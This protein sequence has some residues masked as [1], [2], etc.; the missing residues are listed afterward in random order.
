MF[1]RFGL[2]L[3]VNF[4]VMISLMIILNILGVR[5]YITPMGINYNSLLIICFVYGMGGAFFSLLIS[6]TIAKWTMGLKIISPETRGS[7]EQKLLSLVNQQAKAAGLSK[8]PE[9][10]L[11]DSPEVNAFATGPS[12]N[13][14]LIALST[15]LLQSMNEEQVEG[16][17][18]HEMSHIAN[19]DMVT[20]TLLQ[21]VIN[22]FVM[23]FAK[24]AAWAV[25]NSMKGEDDEGQPSFWLVFAIEMFFTIVFG[26]L[27]MIVVNFFSRYREYEADKG[28]SYLS[29]KAKII[30]ALEALKQGSEISDSRGEALNNFKISSPG[31]KSLL[32]D[33][34]NTHPSLDSRIEALQKSPMA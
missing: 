4:G 18:A 13:N 11:Y 10:A 30:S 14:S 7:Y 22:A 34:L 33:L 19:G 12:K 5:H 9:L 17:L 3:L 23:F 6:K 16:V 25:A 31:K 24:A 2:L 8:A 26:F 20:M 32:L 28:A 29:G 21:G 27:G 1:K 15:G